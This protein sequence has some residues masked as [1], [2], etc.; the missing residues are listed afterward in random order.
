MNTDQIMFLSFVA[1]AC[2]FGYMGWSQ[3]FPYGDQAVVHKRVSPILF[4]ITFC[5]LV[6]RAYLILE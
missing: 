3:S 4:F 1:C 5:W 6:W 2:A